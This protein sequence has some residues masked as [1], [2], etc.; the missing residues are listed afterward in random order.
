MPPVGFHGMISVLL[1]WKARNKAFI[2][3]IISGSILLDADLYISA[4]AFVLTRQE[5]LTTYMHRSFTHSLV[6]FGI[7]FILGV[8]LFVIRNP[9]TKLLGMALFGI[10][11]GGTTHSI[12]DL[13]Y[14]DGV[15]IFWPLVLQKISPFGLSYT[16]L[17]PM[18]QKLYGVADL[19]FESLWWAFLAILVNWKGVD[20]TLQIGFLKVQHSPLI[21]FIAA[22]IEGSLMVIFFFLAFFIPDRDLFFVLLYIPGFVILFI[23]M[24]LPFLL[25]RT[26]YSLSQPSLVE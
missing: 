2:L 15:A 13:F 18:I 1:S 16:N 11:F 3:G 14:V 24:V 26:Y 4:I 21:L 12:L 10:V 5:D 7:I 6:I 9:T 19:A 22:C 23:S 17:S 8:I 20:R 25:R